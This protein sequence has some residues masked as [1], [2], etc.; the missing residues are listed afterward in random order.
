MSK[1]LR[2]LLI[3]TVVALGSLSVAAP[4]QAVVC[5]D[6]PGG[7]CGSVEVLGKEVLRI[8]CAG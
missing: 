7:C 8:D 4:A 3:V 2:S 5:L 6:N 1:K